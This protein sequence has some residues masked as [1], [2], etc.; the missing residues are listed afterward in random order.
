MRPGHREGARAALPLG[1]VIGGFGVSFGVLARSAGMGV[2]APIVMS[3]TT[4]AGSAQFAAASILGVGGGMAA[5]VIAAVLL[6]SRYLPIGISVA[7][8][9][10]GPFWKRLLSAQLLVDESWAIGNVGGGQYD[11]G[12][13]MGAGLVIYLGWVG[14]TVIGAIAGDVIGDPNRLGL[15]AAFPALFLALVVPQLTTRRAVVAAVLGAGIALSLVPFAR[16]GVPIV[17]ASVA[18]LIGLRHR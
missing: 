9:F 11:L 12:R 18:C 10:E 14:G 16:P 4:F 8:A 5:S 1:V 13:I 17:A 3:V 2:L 6:N 15:D 7:P